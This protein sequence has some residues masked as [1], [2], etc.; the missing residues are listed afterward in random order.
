MSEFVQVEI[1]RQ[2]YGD[3]M[4][5]EPD[6]TS[7]LWRVAGHRV[8]HM[9]NMIQ[10]LPR[11]EFTRW[12]MGCKWVHFN[13]V[14]ETVGEAVEARDC[15]YIAFG[16]PAEQAGRMRVI[17]KIL[18]QNGDRYAREHWSWITASGRLIASA[19]GGWAV[20]GYARTFGFVEK[21]ARLAAFAERQ[22]NEIADILGDPEG[23][24]DPDIQTWAW[25]KHGLKIC[26]HP[27]DFR[28]GGTEN[29]KPAEW[30]IDGESADFESVVDVAMEAVVHAE[31]LREI[32]ELAEDADDDGEPLPCD[33]PAEDAGD[34]EEACYAPS[35][36]AVTVA[37]EYVS[38]G[39]PAEDE[40]ERRAVFE[41]EIKTAHERHP[42]AMIGLAHASLDCEFWPPL[43]DVL[44]L[45]CDDGSLR[46]DLTLLSWELARVDDESVFT[47]IFSIEPND[48]LLRLNITSVTKGRSIAGWL[49]ISQICSS[50]VVDLRLNRVAFNPRHLPF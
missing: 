39:L 38:L 50:E 40:E 3:P 42:W 44:G 12:Q 15:I 49:P 37:G 1:F 28:A 30:E 36:L 35:E 10:R 14:L 11:G 4:F 47:L 16:M 25:E 45:F 6:G 7:L 33:L 19:D 18:R 26:V 31:E 32:E 5:E 27:V 21:F 29:L 20:E 46:K 41:F 22:F 9:N 43:H 8:R 13:D 23:W 34:D 2:L 17:Q 48:N 24:P